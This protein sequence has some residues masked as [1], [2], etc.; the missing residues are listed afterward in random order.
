MVKLTGLWKGKDRNGKA[1]LS[2]TV[3]PGAKLLV[4]PNTHKK[5]DSDPDFVAF[6]AS[7]EKAERSSVSEPKH[8]DGELF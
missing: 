8:D 1:I 6:I 3:S 5:R 4:L 2:G 7:V